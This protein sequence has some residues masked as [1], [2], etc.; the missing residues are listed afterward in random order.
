MRDVDYISAFLRVILPIAY[1]YNP[2]LVLVS[3]GFD[4]CKGDPLGC[5]DVT[6][7][8]YGHFIQLIKSLAGGRVVLALEGGYN[9]NSVGYSLA[10]C[11][12]ALLGDPLPSL[13]ICGRVCEQA[14]QSINQTVLNHLPYWNMLMQ[15]KFLISSVPMMGQCTEQLNEEKPDDS[16]SNQ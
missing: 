12:R 2:E 6:P 7:Q 3:A 1:N 13:G 16:F 5:Y 11:C 10:M 8:A 9:V 15:D 14:V 4:A